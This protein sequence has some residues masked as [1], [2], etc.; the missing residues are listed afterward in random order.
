MQ[1][2]C[3]QLS[4]LRTGLTRVTPAMRHWAAL[5]CGLCAVAGA[6]ADVQ[7]FYATQD[8]SVNSSFTLDFGVYGG[9]RSASITT[10]EYTL[11][12]DPVGQST[13][14][15]SYHQTVDPLLLPDGSSTGNMI[16]TI[17]ESLPGAYDPGLGTFTTQDMYVIYFDGD[18][19]AYGLTSPV[20]LPGSASG[21]I[22]YDKDMGGTIFSAWTGQGQ[23][24]NPMDPAHPI[25]FEYACQT[26]TSFTMTPEP[27][28]LA[29]LGLGAL[30]VLRRR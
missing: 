11:E 25:V 15:L 18:L 26:Q 24:S 28:T 22:T 19:S 23:L 16:V 10:T 9:P 21:T 1:R 2:L 17:Q 4:D 5:V 13:R 12:A 6:V 27:G 8:P 14:F 29:L 3:A 30:V 7:H 20:A